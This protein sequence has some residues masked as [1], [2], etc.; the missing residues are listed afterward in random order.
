VDEYR[1]AVA[2]LYASSARSAAWRATAEE[3]GE[4]SD[5]PVILDPISLEEKPSVG[6][7]CVFS[8]DVSAL[9]APSARE[10][11]GGRGSAGEEGGTRLLLRRSATGELLCSGVRR[12]DAG[13]HLAGR[14]G[15]EPFGCYTRGLRES[16]VTKRG[17]KKPPSSGAGWLRVAKSYLAAKYSRPDGL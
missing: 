9:A 1:C 16:L 4:R 10:S 17:Q 7:A 8:S 2:R 3:A 12:V 14:A 13:T 15:T 11:A 5:I 6:R